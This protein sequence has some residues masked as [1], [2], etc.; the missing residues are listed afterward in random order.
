[1]LLFFVSLSSLLVQWQLHFRGL[2]MMK[3]C[4]LFQHV[5]Q[6]PNNIKIHVYE[7]IQVRQ[8]AVILIFLMDFCL[9]GLYLSLRHS[10]KHDS[11]IYTHVFMV[12]E[13]NE[14]NDNYPRPCVSKWPPKFQNG[15]HKKCFMRINGLLRCIEA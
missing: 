12:K 10:Q 7:I 9:V 5:I 15:R 4:H 3:I 1:M 6:F 11:G 2:L 8:M 13:F 14:N